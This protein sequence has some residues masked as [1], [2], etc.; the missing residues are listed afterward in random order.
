MSL[1]GDR[2]VSVDTSFEY[3]LY[4]DFNLLDVVKGSGRIT[5]GIHYNQ[6]G[7]SVLLEGFFFAGG[8]ASVIGI[9]TID[10]H[11]YVGLGYAAQKSQGGVAGHG[12]FSVTVGFWPA[13]W[14]FSY[15]VDYGQS[16]EQKTNAERIA[17]S[18]PNKNDKYT[19]DQDVFTDEDTWKWVKAKFAPETLVR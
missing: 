17:G 13:E 2:L 8:R 6:S 15:S 1:A 9:I 19:H 18:P 14:S 7:T 4:G 5:I 16:G 10:A 3:G 12:D 11:L